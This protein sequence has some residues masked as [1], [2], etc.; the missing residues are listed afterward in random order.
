MRMKNTSKFLLSV[1][2]IHFGGQKMI[3]FRSKERALV[4]ARKRRLPLDLL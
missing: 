1:A 3:Y 4:S 2:T